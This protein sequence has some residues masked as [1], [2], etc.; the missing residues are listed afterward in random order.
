MKIGFVVIEL[1]YFISHRLDLAKKLS[2]FH[3]V[4]VITSTASASKRTLEEIRDEGIFLHHLSNRKDSKN[5]LGFFKYLISL[6]KV[7]RYLNIKHIFYVTLEMSILGAILNN[8]LSLKRSY[9]LITGLGPFFSNKKPKYILYRLIKKLSFVALK[10]K[11]NYLFIFQNNDDL[12]T[13]LNNKFSQRD[14][15]LIIEGNGIDTSQF[16][17]FERDISKQIIFLFASKLIYPK[18]IIEF[19]NA[20]KELKDKY[21]DIKF[22]IAGAYDPANPD[23]ISKKEFEMI[24][25]SAFL[26]YLGF[27]D[28]KDM[29]NYLKKSTILV[30]PSYGEGLP[31]I[32]LEAASTGMPLILSNVRGS[33]DCLIHEKNGFFVESK[34]YE[35]IKNAMLKFLNKRE[36]I[37]EFG[38]FS[39]DLVNK[40][41]SL[42]LIANKYLDIIDQ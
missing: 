2:K 37:I 19:I 23:S 12:E 6:R 36:I 35:A 41:F 8:T 18:G 32:A 15:S 10:I 16:K 39:S 24:Q 34:N 33:R 14:T 29:P 27:V 13:F 38:R 22:H 9:F 4:H 21:Q 30:L 42:D 40:K 31:K 25:N 5:L 7:I 20:S 3:E 11:K 26:E 28:I 1:D 17:F